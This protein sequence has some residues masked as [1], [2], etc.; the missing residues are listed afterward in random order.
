MLADRFNDASGIQWWGVMFGMRWCHGFEERLLFSLRICQ[1][2]H[3]AFP[4]AEKLSLGSTLCFKVN[5]SFFIL[6]IG[7]GD[8]LFVVR[9]GFFDLRLQK[10]EH[11][12]SCQKSSQ[13]P[14]CA[15]RS[16]Q[17]PAIY[18]AVAHG[19]S[20]WPGVHVVKDQFS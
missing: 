13:V 18:F 1:D 19:F 14:E 3:P 6:A 7:L 15:S 5:P 12:L 8:D 10:I 2:L 9:I 20:V 17:L 11:W 4:L 16:Y